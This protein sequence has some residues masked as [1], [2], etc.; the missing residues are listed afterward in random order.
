MKLHALPQFPPPLPPP[1]RPAG[2]R[3]A[4]ALPFQA[5]ALRAVQPA[6]AR[7]SP[8]SAR[9]NAP[10]PAAGSPPLRNAP[11]LAEN[12]VAAAPVAYVRGSLV[13]VQA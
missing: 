12:A 4:L 7:R 11:V 3:A 13:D 2:D 5:E 8:A 10:A 9:G 1:P 6:P